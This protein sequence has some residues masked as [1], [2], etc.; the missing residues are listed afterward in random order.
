MKKRTRL[1]LT[2][3]YAVNNGDMALVLALSESLK[4]RVLRI[5]KPF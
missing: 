5:L 2:N 1:L 3:A 4:K